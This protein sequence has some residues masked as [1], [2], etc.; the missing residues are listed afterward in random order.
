ML[1]L[2]CDVECCKLGSI[3]LLPTLPPPLYPFLSS[4]SPSS[5][6]TRKG[7][8]QN[9]AAGLLSEGLAE[10]AKGRREDEDA[11]AAH[12]A[13]LAAEEG[14]R[15]AKKGL[16]STKAAPLHRIADLSTDVSKARAHLP[17][18]QRARAP[19]HA[20]VEHI[21]AG[22]RVKLFI[23]SENCRSVGGGG[24]RGLLAT[25]TPSLSPSSITASSSAS[26]RYEPRP[27]QGRPTAGPMERCGRCV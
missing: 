5:F 22:N 10:L 8:R 18:L 12:A 6:Q 20:V 13:L 4:T 24:R 11:C 25:K 16:H 17:S 3:L 26:L 9:V 21:F 23:P 27:R 19:L 7:D 15:A 1:L 14:A 2:R